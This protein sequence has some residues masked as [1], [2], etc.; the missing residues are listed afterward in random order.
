MV[1]VPPGRTTCPP[2]TPTAVDTLLNLALLSTIDPFKR[3]L[4]ASE[5][6]TNTGVLLTTA[7]ITATAPTSLINRVLVS[8]RRE[9]TNCIFSPRLRDQ[10]R[11]DVIIE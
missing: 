8:K 6:R 4:L 5:E 2:T 1:V 10:N 11:P 7:S 9:E 3:P